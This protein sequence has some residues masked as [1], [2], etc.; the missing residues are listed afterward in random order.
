MIP[1]RDIN[2]TKTRPVITWAIIVLNAMVWFY[3]FGL[4]DGMQPFVDRWGVVPYYLTLPVLSSWVTPISSMFLHAGW[5]HV[6]LN[7]WFLHIFGDNI[8]DELGRGR[9]VAFY[10]VCGLAAVALQVAIDPASQVPMVGASGAIAGVLGGY[11]MLHPRAPIVTMLPFVF[12]E[13]PAWAFLFVWFGLQLV[14]ALG[15]LGA[16]S[17]GGVAF[18]A[19]IGGFLAGFALV[20][21]MRS[22]VDAP[23]PPSALEVESGR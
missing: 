18:F 4:T 10:L 13:L 19:H 11:M 8:E 3:Q 14:S 5:M 7:M 21:V 23:A 6:I 20:R 9:Y 12:V 17:S 2:P 15:A 16:E 22:R 1:L